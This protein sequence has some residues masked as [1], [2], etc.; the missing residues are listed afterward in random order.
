M[1]YKKK[2][3]FVKMGKGKSYER[4]RIVLSKKKKTKQEIKKREEDRLK[5][6]KEW[7]SWWG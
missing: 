6:I 5:R 1:V 4:G 7:K 3:T 2:C